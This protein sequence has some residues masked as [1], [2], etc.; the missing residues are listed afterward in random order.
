MTKIPPKALI[1]GLYVGS[2]PDELKDLNFIEYSMI[3]I[4][5][6]VSKIR[7]VT[8]DH[9][10]TKPGPTYTFINDLVKTTATLPR[11]IDKDV[12]AILRHKKVC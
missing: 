10:R 1:N 7:I 5:S 11:M 12:I 4:H 2:L 6:V 8:G 9:F 3:S